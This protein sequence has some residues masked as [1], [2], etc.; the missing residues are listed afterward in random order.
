HHRIPDT[1]Y[2]QPTTQHTIPDTPYPIPNTRLMTEIRAPRTD[3]LDDLLAL[4]CE[5]FRL[6]YSSAR[7]PFYQDPFFDLQN[8]R[9]LVE[10][11]VV[12][13]CLT[14][15]PR[16]IWIGKAAVS[17]AGVADLS[18]LQSHRGRGLATELLKD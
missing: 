13:S 5:A 16:T 10:E 17:V 11:G 1:L 12:A 18:T 9:V 15:V 6:P 8:K 4:M 3:E 2:P 7:G 14:L